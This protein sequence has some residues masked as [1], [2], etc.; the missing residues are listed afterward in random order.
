MVAH[1][2]PEFQVA[3]PGAP[4]NP[5]NQIFSCGLRAHALAEVGQFDFRPLALKQIAAI[6]LLEALDCERERG[7]CDMAF[8][9]PPVCAY[10]Q[11]AWAEPHAAKKG[12]EAF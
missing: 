1:C 12:A 11:E 6:L 3:F 5:S 10:L 2:H 8:A 9:L 7:L 4:G